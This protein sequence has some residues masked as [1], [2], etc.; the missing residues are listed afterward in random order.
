MSQS[1]ELTPSLKNKNLQ[2]VSV[3]FLDQN[4]IDQFKNIGIYPGNDIY[5]CDIKSNNVINV[6]VDNIQ[7]AIRLS[8]AK[9]IKVKILD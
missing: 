2:I 4:Y 5:V 3:N 8:D 1:I 7:Y 9:N 6:I